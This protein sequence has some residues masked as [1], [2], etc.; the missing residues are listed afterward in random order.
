MTHFA[1]TFSFWTVKHE[2]CHLTCKCWLNCN[3]NLFDWSKR[4]QIKEWLHINSTNRNG[5]FFAFVQI[6]K[7]KYTMICSLLITNVVASSARF[8]SIGLI[9][10][11]ISFEYRKSILTTHFNVKQRRILTL[12]WR[13]VCF[14]FHLIKNLCFHNSK[15]HRCVHKLH[16]CRQCELLLHDLLGIGAAMQANMKEKS[17]T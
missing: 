1:R 7:G 3:S 16:V 13:L 2:I 12:N 14:H 6:K 11:H 5:R 8:L 17:Q 9:A 15:T 4:S 10:L